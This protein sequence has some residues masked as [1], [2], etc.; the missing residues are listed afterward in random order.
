[1]K[2]DLAL[3]R[4]LHDHDIAALARRIHAS[5][6][7]AAHARAR[8]FKASH[9]YV[10]RFKR[11]HGLYTGKPRLGKLRKDTEEELKEIDKFKRDARVMYSKI[12][13]HLSSTWTRH[14]GREKQCR[15]KC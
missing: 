8:T 11:M 4:P 14:D 1:M 10:T 2:T 6:T 7:T 15:S 12:P 5:A 13:S 3:G 9:R